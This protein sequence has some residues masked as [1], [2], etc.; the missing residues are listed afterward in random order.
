MLGQ[1]LRG[2]LLHCLPQA[3]PPVSLI[4][5]KIDLLPPAEVAAAVRQVA[6]WGYTAIP[7]SV[8]TG[9]GLPELAE[10][11]AGRV[12]VLAGPSGADAMLLTVWIDT[13]YSHKE[14]YLCIC[15]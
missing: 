5:N 12:S 9:E 7:V 1:T 13:E 4:F 11:L 10:H 14:H 3:G 6:E 8:A 15:Y 2:S